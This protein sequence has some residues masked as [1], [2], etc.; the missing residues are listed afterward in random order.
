MELVS[1]G[2]CP[3]IPKKEGGGQAQSCG[4]AGCVLALPVSRVAAASFLGAAVVGGTGWPLAPGSLFFTVLTE[5][6]SPWGPL[7]PESCYIPWH[8]W[9][10]KAVCTWAP[11]G[12][13]ARCMLEQN[14]VLGLP[15]RNLAL[16]RLQPQGSPTTLP[17]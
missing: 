15:A 4:L 7:G 14:L 8:S 6:R 9:L 2:P 16:P 1:L 17:L 11:A 3:S 5:L 13:T 10:G 12:H